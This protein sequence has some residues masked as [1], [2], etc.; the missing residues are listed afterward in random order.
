MSDNYV[1]NV[2]CADAR[3]LA[4]ISNESVDLIVTSPDIPKHVI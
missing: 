3:N 4:M 2:F 1:N